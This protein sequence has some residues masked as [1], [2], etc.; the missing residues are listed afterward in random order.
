MK[1]YKFIDAN[2]L[3]DEMSN[4]L[5]KEDKN[6]NRAIIDSLLYDDCL[7]YDVKTIQ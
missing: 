3:N 4:D 7:L 1:Q 6:L 5:Y 2:F